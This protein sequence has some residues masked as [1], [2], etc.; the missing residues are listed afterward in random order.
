MTL[1]K[2]LILTSLC[3][4]FLLGSVDVSYSGKY[5]KKKTEEKI[6]VTQKTEKTEKVQKTEQKKDEKIKKYTFYFK[7]TPLSE[8]F[9]V[10]GMEGLNILY[11]GDLKGRGQVQLP[12]FP[13][14]NVPQNVS[15]NATVVT[16]EIPQPPITSVLPPSTPSPL[17]SPTPSFS[18]NQSLDDIVITLMLNDV[19]LNEAIDAVCKVADV[20]CEKKSENTYFVRRYDI[21]EINMSLLFDSYSLEIKTGLS[22]SSASSGVSVTSGT[23][24][25]G[26]TTT[27]TT[28]GGISQTSDSFEIKYNKKDFINEIKSLLTKEGS[29]IYSDRGIVYVVD[30]PSGIEKVKKFL[31]RE[32][33]LQKPIQMN[34]KLVEINLN[35]GN[36]Y[37]IDWNAFF[38]DM[39]NLGKKWNI[40][41][42]E[43]QIGTETGG[44]AIPKGFV[45]RIN[46]PGKMNLILK[47]LENQGD[48]K[49]LRNWNVFAKTG[50]PVVLSD[51]ESV[52][53]LSEGVVVTDRNVVQTAN[54]SYIDTGI[55]ISIVGS[56]I[57][58][59]RIDGSI[60]VSLSTLV[61]IKNLRTTEN[62][63]FVPVVK[64]SSVVVPMNVKVGDV[65]LLSG[66]KIDAIRKT[67]TGVPFLSRIPVLGYL[68]KTEETNTINSELLLLIEIK[69]EEEVKNEK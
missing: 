9:K 4:G 63:Y 45:F 52:P 69:E 12:V 14:Q 46:A 56:R 36:A 57:D 50:V 5:L 67:Q 11:Q 10:L 30:R 59:E 65:L 1:Y 22:G 64:S 60:N 33:L 18:S 25:T 47:M 2:K 58:K 68:F 44:G 27:T 43:L 3:A 26:T 28:G 17:P 13:L 31:E 54:V 16:S 39:W 20:Y 55:K 24:T 49:I 42:D 29:L 53:Y 48:V 15:Q 40:K 51:V 23:T 19:T 61:E 38:S 62:P 32:K 66:F 35:K 7:G 21:Y 34:V 41:V 37:G 8:V 6:E